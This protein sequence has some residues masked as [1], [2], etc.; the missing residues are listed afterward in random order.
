MK[1]RPKII[2]SARK[3]LSL[4]VTRDGEVVVRAPKGL[5]E[6]YIL[7]FAGRHEEWIERRLAA[8]AQKPSLDL[9]DGGT[10][11]LFGSRYLIA[12]GRTGI[13]D[14]KLFLPEKEREA[15][16]ARFL[17]KFSLEV[18]GLLTDRIAQRWGFRYR[19]VRISSART[20]WGS[21]NREGTI[22]YTFRIAFLPPQLVEYV[23]VHELAHTVCF[24]HSPH[25]WAEVERVIPDYKTR[26]KALKMCRAMEYL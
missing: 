26:R 21:C 5:S 4:T 17:K 14:G 15:A 16:L 9:S 23:A 25:F 24:D 12:T 20:R 11:V 3:T 19:A 22:A 6:E 10:L 8:V 1:I 18:M 2:R 13:G 7:A